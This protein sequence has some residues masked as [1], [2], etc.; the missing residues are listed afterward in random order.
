MNSHE[1]PR[2]SFAE[3][4]HGYGFLTDRQITAA[5]ENR[6]LLD[7]GTTDDSCIRHASYTLRLG[8]RVEIAEAVRANSEHRRDFQ[9]RDIAAGD[10][11]DLNPGD[12][13]KLYSIEILDLPNEVLAFTVARGLL[14]IESLVPENTYV[15]PGFHGSLYTTVTNLSNR[16]VT[17]SYGDPIARLFFYKLSEPVEERFQAGAARGLKQR[18]PSRR[19]TV[20]GTP[21]ECKNPSFRQ[22]L[23]DTKLLPLAGNQVSTMLV[24]QNRYLALVGIAAVIWPILLLVANSSKFLKDNVGSI[25]TNLVASAIF[26]VIIACTSWIWSKFSGTNG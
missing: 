22:L 13:A 18:L 9:V 4:V 6:Y 2:P 14:Y 7:P 25:V 15:D 23:E 26:A 17:L 12:T 21:E 3:L 8:Q 5:L 11:L 10:T 20:N 1:R 16:V 24:R 19:A